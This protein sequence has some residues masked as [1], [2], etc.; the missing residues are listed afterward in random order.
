VLTAFR[1][2]TRE[3][4]QTMVNESGRVQRDADFGG[5]PPLCFGATFVR[6]EAFR[7]LFRDGMALVETSASYLDGDGRTESH[8]LSRRTAL[9]YASESMRLTTRLMQ[10]ASWL[11]V[12]RAVAEGEI[13]PAQAAREKERVKLVPQER[14]LPDQQF[15][16]L[17]EPIRDL[18]GQSLRLHARIMHLDGLMN[19]NPAS[20]VVRSPV[21]QQ[22]HLLR[23]MFE[24]G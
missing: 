24:V 9:S 13:T 21:S 5:E 23:S 1:I 22:Q 12:Q 6:S 7:T 18:I 4:G 14:G 2:G 8:R 17:P 11:L 20:R 19:S 10:I 3:Q 16:E 15:G